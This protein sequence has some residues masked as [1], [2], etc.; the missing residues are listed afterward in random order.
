VKVGKTN[1]SGYSLLALT[2]RKVGQAKQTVP[3]T[4]AV[5]TGHAAARGFCSIYGLV[6]G[7][8][9]RTR[10]VGAFWGHGDGGA[11]VWPIVATGRDTT[12]TWANVGDVGQGHWGGLHAWGIGLRRSCR[13]LLLAARQPFAARHTLP[14]DVAV[15]R[16]RRFSHLVGWMATRCCRRR[17]TITSQSPP[18]RRPFPKLARRPR[19]AIIVQRTLPPKIGPHHAVRRSG[20]RVEEEVVDAAFQHGTTANRLGTPSE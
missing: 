10:H 8:G 15:E 6:V 12:Q 3:K 9:K 17:F 18:R 4:G 11:G 5:P 14:I 13:L 20:G 7:G 2:L 19:S 1:N 16:W